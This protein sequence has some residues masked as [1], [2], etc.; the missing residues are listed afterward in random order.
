MSEEASNEPFT[1]EEVGGM[2]RHMNDDHAD[3]V[4]AYARHFGGQSDATKATLTGITAAVMRLQVETPS[5]IFAL[6]IPFDR[7][8]EST[9]DAHR[10]LIRMS[11]QAKRGLENAT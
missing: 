9:H 1:A 2:V 10:T 4:L 11:K 5:G 8:L 3:S 6:E 7:S